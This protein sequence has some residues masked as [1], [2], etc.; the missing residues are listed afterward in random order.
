MSATTAVF[1]ILGSA[2]IVLTGIVGLTRSVWKLAQ[3]VRD[4]MIETKRLGQVTAQ[5]STEMVEA[6]QAT[7]QNT[8]AVSE[9][10]VK[11]DGRL[12]SLE[13]RMTAVEAAVRATK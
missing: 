11:M 5:L 1:A 13:V 8:E 10:S 2:V 3:S 4:S 6:K 12:T 9:L 7:H